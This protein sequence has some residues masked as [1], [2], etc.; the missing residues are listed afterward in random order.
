[1]KAIK[2]L[3]IHVA[4]YHHVEGSGLEGE[5]VEHLD[6]VG[7]AV[8]E[9][10][11]GWDCVPQVQKSVDLNRRLGRTK[12]GRRDKA[13][14]QV[15]GAVV[16]VINRVLQIQ[17]QVFFDT[18]FAAPSDQDC[19]KIGPDC[20]I[21]SLVGTGQGAFLD[22]GAN[23]HS[24]EFAR[25]RAQARLD[26]SKRL[27]PLQLRKSHDSIVLGRRQKP[28]LRICLVTLHNYGKT[29]PRYELH[30][31][32]KQRLADVHGQPQEL[33]SIPESYPFLAVCSLNRH[34]TKSLLNP[35]PVSFSALAGII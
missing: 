22:Q 19:S 4:A 3:E 27:P 12:Q 34:N 8:G 18:D 32:C 5:H 23:P 21:S 11:K 30:D 7:L 35:L 26:V 14:A 1:M 10:D 6:V 25:V 16:Q 33:L 28:H 20:P 9:V 24:I 17:P 31:L 2:P 13:H 15:D 29:Q